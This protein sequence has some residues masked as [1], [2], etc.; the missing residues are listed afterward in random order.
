MPFC[1]L[2]L[3]LLATAPPAFALSSR[4]ICLLVGGRLGSRSDIVC[5]PKSCPV[6]DEGECCLE[7][8]AGAKFCSL[9]GEAPCIA[10]HPDPE[11]EEKME[12]VT[13]KEQ[14]EPADKKPAK[15]PLQK[16]QQLKK[17][18]P[19]P[20]GPQK[21]QGP[22]K[23]DGPP[24]ERDRYTPPGEEKKRQPR[25][26]EKRHEKELNKPAAKPSVKDR[27][28]LEAGGILDQERGVACCPAVCGRCGGAGCGKREG[29]LDCCVGYV[30]EVYQSCSHKKTAPCTFMSVGEH[31]TYGKHV[32]PAQ[33]AQVSLVDD[34]A[35]AAGEEQCK[36]VG[37]VMSQHDDEQRALA[38]C[39]AS[40]KAP[41]SARQTGG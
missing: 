40:C 30:E 9:A 34:K 38:C 27:Q 18:P 10:V 21:K 4:Q 35:K 13:A 36:R 1:L 14:K 25:S 20:K 15:K 37:G 16:K 32:K 19:P 8:D 24:K 26:A 3:L 7:Q 17:K 12:Q 23:P 33:T 28:C 31:K 39:P 2:L 41:C 11:S 29:G 6:A 22:S 5:C